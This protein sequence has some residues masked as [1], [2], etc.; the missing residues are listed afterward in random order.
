MQKALLSPH[1]ALLLTNRQIHLPVK[2][3]Y[4]TPATPFNRQHRLLERPLR[5]IDMRLPDMLVLRPLAA[6]S[7]DAPPP[8]RNAAGSPS[9]RPARSRKPT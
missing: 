4:H 1:P 8:P 5:L 7:A 2:V 9:V 6:A 3:L